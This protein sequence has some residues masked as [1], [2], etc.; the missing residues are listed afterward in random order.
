MTF[1]VR[2]IDELFG[3]DSGFIPGKLVKKN[4][5]FESSGPV[6]LKEFKTGPTYIPPARITVF[7]FFRTMAGK[8]DSVTDM[9]Y[10]GKFT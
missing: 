8:Y 7:E 4:F 5:K 6:T 9:D 3:D 10:L 1:F 2:A